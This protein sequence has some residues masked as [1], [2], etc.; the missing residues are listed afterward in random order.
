LATLLALLCVLP[1]CRDAGIFDAD[2]NRRPNVVLILIDTLR[3]DHVG[4]LGYERATTPHLDALAEESWVFERATSAA[5]WTN[6]AFAAVFTGREPRTLFTGAAAM[7]IP[8]AVPRIS[9]LLGAEGYYT[10]GIISHTFLGE[11]YDFHLGFD[12]WDQTSIRGPRG[13]TSPEI[14]ERA[15]SWLEEDPSQPFLLVLHYFDPHPDFRPRPGFTFGEPYEGTVHSGWGNIRQLQKLAREGALTDKNIQHLRDV[16]D[17]EI[18][19]TDA[20]IGKLLDALRRRGLFDEALVVVTADHGEAFMDRPSRWIGHGDNLH[21]ELVHVPLIVHL[22]GQS[23]GE[24]VRDTVGTID[25]LP[26]ILDVVG[27]EAASSTEFQGRSLVGD[28]SDRPVFSETQRRAHHEAITQGRWKLIYEPRKGT[29]AL[30]DI[31]ADPN[32]LHDQSHLHPDVA[33]ELLTLLETWEREHAPP[34]APVSP[35]ELSESEKERLRA[36]GYADD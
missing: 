19:W 2:R 32:E 30:F 22:P 21:K 11:Q 5:P 26:T 17:S 24:R 4:H 23:V 27:A 25:V 33:N 31:E 36:L 14:T 34:S 9:Q 8:E 18:A 15:L 16:Y 13:N 1:G 6:P 28:R 10:A 7:K 3:A 12:H 20:H 29:T 35:P